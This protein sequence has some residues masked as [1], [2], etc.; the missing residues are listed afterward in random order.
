MYLSNE[1]P[2]MIEYALDDY[3]YIRFYLAP[4]INDEK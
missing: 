4:R 3:G 2:L 1:S